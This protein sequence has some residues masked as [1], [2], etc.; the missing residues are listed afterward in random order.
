MCGFT[1]NAQTLTCYKLRAFILLSMRGCQK[2]SSLF[3]QL[4]RLVAFV[5]VVVVRKNKLLAKKTDRYCS[6][7]IIEGCGKA[8]AA[9]E[10]KT[11]AS[12]PLP[13]APPHAAGWPIVITPMNVKSQVSN[14]SA[15]PKPVD[16]E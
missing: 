15:Y 14:S 8:L 5:V 3:Q 9:S 6:K 13:P 7:L 1:D 11:Q 2:T 12:S 16:C 4:S 10:F